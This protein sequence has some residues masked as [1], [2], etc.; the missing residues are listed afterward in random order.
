VGRTGYLVGY[1]D[2]DG[3]GEGAAGVV[4]GRAVLGEANADGEAEG[5]GGGGT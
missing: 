3:A 1:S 5:E 2:A 4:T